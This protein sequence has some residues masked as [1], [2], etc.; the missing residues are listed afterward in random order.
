WRSSPRCKPA[1]TGCSS[2]AGSLCRRPS[3]AERELRG[4]GRRE[5]IGKRRGI[6][7]PLGLVLA[8]LVVYAK[9]FRGAFV[10]DDLPHIVDNP[11][12]RTMWS[13]LRP[14]GPV[15]GVWRPLTTWTFALNYA[16]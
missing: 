4:S 2:G 10:L 1:S 9:S 15:A 8:G 16:A 7:V 14:G 3:L 6:L 11:G 12:I 13:G 5:V